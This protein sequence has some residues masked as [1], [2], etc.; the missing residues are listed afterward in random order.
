LLS[1][2][3]SVIGEVYGDIIIIIIIIIIIKIF[4][5]EPFHSYKAD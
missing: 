4:N 1:K 3:Q 5:K 2:N